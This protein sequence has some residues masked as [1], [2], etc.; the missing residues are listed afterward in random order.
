M[1]FKLLRTGISQKEL[2]G[3]LCSC[4]LFSKYHVSLSESHDFKQTPLLM[5]HCI[6]GDNCYAS[7][8]V[9]YTCKCSLRK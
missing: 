3:S 7:K 4:P 6:S 5:L 2:A 1:I 9:Q 8:T